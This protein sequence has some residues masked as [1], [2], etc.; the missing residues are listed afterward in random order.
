MWYNPITC[1]GLQGR[2]FTFGEYAGDGIIPSRI[3]K[4]AKMKTTSTAPLVALLLAISMLF[5]TPLALAQQPEVPA[6][7]PAE[8]EETAELGGEEAE[9]SYGMVKSVSADQIVISEYDYEADKDVD[10]TYTVPADVKIEGAASL[11]EIAVGDAVDID[12]LVKDGQKV[13]SALT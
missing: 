3:N 2:Q 12:F 10:V 8:A 9:F 7:A 1:I 6:V 4:G 5:P 13:A 11:Q